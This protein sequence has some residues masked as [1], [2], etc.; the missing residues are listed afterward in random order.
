M[1][2]DLLFM[3]DSEA[4]DTSREARRLVEVDYQE[5]SIELPRSCPSTML[6]HLQG[7]FETQFITSFRMIK[8][9]LQTDHDS[10]GRERE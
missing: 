9:T 4:A 7:S 2:L 6:S 10:K 5:T 8:V 1:I 3:L